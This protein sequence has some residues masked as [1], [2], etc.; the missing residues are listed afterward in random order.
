M[1]ATMLGLFCHLIT[2]VKHLA[3]DLSSTSFYRQ[4]LKSAPQPLGPVRLQNNLSVRCSSSSTSF[5]NYERLCFLCCA[6]TLGM[7]CKV[8]LH[9]RNR[10]TSASERFVCPYGS[11]P[12]HRPRPGR[13]GAHPEVF[14]HLRYTPTRV[15]LGF[16]AV[17]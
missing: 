4:E 16:P 2:L 7:V 15:R 14:H 11:S 17:N 6:A 9:D 5:N 1:Y 12:A 10:F 13:L 3:Q 8:T